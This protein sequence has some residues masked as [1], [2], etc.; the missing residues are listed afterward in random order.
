MFG[1]GDSSGTHQEW[2]D[3]APLDATLDLDEDNPTEDE[4]LDEW[5]DEVA[6]PA[7]DALEVET[8]ED[9]AARL[10]RARQTWLRH[11]VQR[12]YANTEPSALLAME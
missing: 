12:T 2:P 6:D 3:E 1:S 11:G 10:A 7:L 5:P 4:W 8:A 9:R